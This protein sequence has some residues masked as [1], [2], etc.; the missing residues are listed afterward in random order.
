MMPDGTPT[1]STT[2]VCPRCGAGDQLSTIDIIEAT[3]PLERAEI[4]SNRRIGSAPDWTPNFRYG[5]GSTTVGIECECG[6]Q[7][8][9]EWQ[10]EDRTRE[11]LDLLITSDEYDQQEQNR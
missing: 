1:S 4:V 7:V 2:L 8:R 5:D 10:A 3:V 6:W 9:V 11:M